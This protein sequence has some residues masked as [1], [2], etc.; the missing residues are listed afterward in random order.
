VANDLASQ[1]ARC[2]K[3]EAISYVVQTALKLLDEALAGNALRA[4]RLLVV[5]AELTFEGEID[6]FRRADI[7]LRGE[8]AL[9]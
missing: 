2:G 6:A 5:L 8:T 1:T 4:R 3:A 7:S 9:K